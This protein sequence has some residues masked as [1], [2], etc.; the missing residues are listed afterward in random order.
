MIK[1][2]QI[3]KP[4]YIFFVNWSIS[5]SNDQAQWQTT[6]LLIVW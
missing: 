6:C 3:S 1:E 5:A 4:L 2:H